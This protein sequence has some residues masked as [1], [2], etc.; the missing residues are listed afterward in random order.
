VE[1]MTG[2]RI[3]NSSLKELAMNSRVFR[4]KRV[5]MPTYTSMFPDKYTKEE[6]E[7][8]VNWGSSGATRE[9]YYAAAIVITP[10]WWLARMFLIL[11]VAYRGLAVCKL[12]TGRYWTV[13]E[14]FLSE[15]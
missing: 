10:C 6:I 3:C 4:G 7:L 14:K 9:L 12:A 1:E 8:A 11:H 13:K 2:M 5:F 15:T